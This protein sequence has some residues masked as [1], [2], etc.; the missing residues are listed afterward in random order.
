MTLLVVLLCSHL[1]F[2]RGVWLVAAGGPGCKFALVSA[3]GITT[4]HE[5]E[6]EEEEG[7]DSCIRGLVPADLSMKKTRQSMESTQRMILPFTDSEMLRLFDVLYFTYS[8]WMMLFTSST[9]VEYSCADISS[10]TPLGSRVG[11]KLRASSLVG[12]KMT[13]S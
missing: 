2:G 8:F 1:G 5:E 10:S 6:E 7:Q 3:F 4:E 13:L 12:T 11:L 9:T